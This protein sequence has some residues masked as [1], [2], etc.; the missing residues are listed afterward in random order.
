MKL[1]LT[2]LLLVLGVFVTV[3]LLQKLVNTTLRKEGFATSLEDED[4]ISPEAFSYN[5]LQVVKGP[6]R[7][8]STQL[9]DLGAWKERVDLARLSPVE[10]ARKNLTANLGRAN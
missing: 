10:L 9:L 5:L 1:H 8:L 2:I 4:R 3:L 7:R 6:I